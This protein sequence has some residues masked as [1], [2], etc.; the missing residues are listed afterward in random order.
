MAFPAHR[1]SMG[2]SVLAAEWVQ[3]ERARV[4]RLG[5]VEAPFVLAER[6]WDA[7]RAYGRG[8]GRAEAGTLPPGLDLR[9]LAAELRA[10]AALDDVALRALVEAV[11][12]QLA[13]E[14]PHV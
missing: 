11:A 13:P 6:A 12:A 9:A 7:G 4:A 2:P 3:G 14:A 5:G 8:E 1:P 10:G